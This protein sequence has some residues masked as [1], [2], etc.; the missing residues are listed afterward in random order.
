MVIGARGAR[1]RARPTR[2]TT[3]AATRS[4]TTS[5]RATCSSPTA[6]GCAAKSLDTFCPLGPVV[7]D[8]RRSR[9]TAS[10]ATDAASTARSMQDSNTDRDD[11]RRRRADQLLLA[12]L[13]ARARR[14]DPHRHAVGLRRVHGAQALARSTATSSSARS[15]A[16]ACCAT[17]SWRSEMRGRTSPSP[18]TRSSALLGEG[19]VVIAGGTHVMPRLNTAAT[20][21]DARQP[22]PRRACAGIEVDGDTRHA[23]ARRRR[24]PSSAPT[25][26]RRSCAPSIESIASPTIRNL[27]TVGGNLFVPAAARRPR[28]LPARARR[29]ADVA[30]DAH[31][32]DGSSTAP[33]VVTAVRFTVP[34]ALV[35]H[36]GDA[37]QAEL[38]LD[39]HRGRPTACGS[40]SAAS[41]REPVARAE[42]RRRQALAAGDIEAAG[43]GRARGRRPVRR[44]LRQR[45]V[46]PPRPARPRPPRPARREPMP[47][48]VIELDVNDEPRE[49]LAPPGTTLLS[50]LRE[51]ARPDR[52]QARLRAGH[53]RHLHLPARRRGRHVA[54]WSRS[55]RSTARRVDDARGHDARRR[56]RRRSS[57][58]S[59]TASPPS[60]A[61]ARRG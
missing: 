43:R 47:S 44:R 16:S 13:H 30:S 17:R 32:R 7:V 56:A 23:S 19:A 38:R 20:D 58:R 46:P 40:R 1:R 50:A 3:C 6:S 59:W 60:A 42:A 25:S 49:F 28:G 5:P 55:R 21:V 8:A 2:S 11:L 27:A 9:R 53:V 57:R 29:E 10:A 18:S 45:L 54:A 34:R 36:E 4:A 61:S 24:W 37:P 26:A 31:A 22:A 51:H 48:S 12:Q 39:R 14:R 52:R 35:L 15:R 41:R 33:G